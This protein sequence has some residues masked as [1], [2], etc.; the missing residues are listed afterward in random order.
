LLA[1]IVGALCGWEKIA[2]ASGVTVVCLLLRSLKDVLHGLARCVELADVEATLKFAVMSV[3]IL[4]LLPNETF[5]PPP[6]DV[7]NPCKIW[8]MVVLSAGLNF[9]GRRTADI[10]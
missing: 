5:V 9:L 10:R 6:V 8:L 4:P 3:I 2:V 7:I 1:F